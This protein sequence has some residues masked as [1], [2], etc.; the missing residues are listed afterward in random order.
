[1]VEGAHQIYIA[2]QKYKGYYYAA[3]DS[4]HIDLCCRSQGYKG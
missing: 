2:P 4:K 3:F 1:M